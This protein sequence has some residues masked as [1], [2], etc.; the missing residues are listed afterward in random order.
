MTNNQLKDTHSVLSEVLRL[1]HLS[2]DAINF[3]FDQFKEGEL[4]NPIHALGKIRS[5][6]NKEALPHEFF[7]GFGINTLILD[8]LHGRLSLCENNF[9]DAII[10]DTAL[11]KWNDW[12]NGVIMEDLKMLFEYAQIVEFDKWS[13]VKHAS[14][15][16]DNLR[17]DVIKPI[18]RNDFDF[19][20]YLG[21]TKKKFAF[22][23]DEFLDIVCDFSLYGRVTLVLDEQNIDNLW[24]MFFKRNSYSE[25]SI[26]PGFREKCRSVFDLINIQ[27]L[28]VESFPATLM[29]SGQQQFEVETRNSFDISRIDKNHFDAGYILGLLL[30]MDISHSIV[31]GIA[32]S[33]VYTE[34]GTKPNRN[35]LFYYLENW[36]REKESLKPD[37][38]QLA[39]G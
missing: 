5:I 28:L 7:L 22:E 34:N 13:D 11:N 37:E 27:Y 9:I 29:Y 30:K 12:K 38:S 32:V 35:T 21:D 8:A 15:L 4:L 24:A 18:N 14:D 1:L 10:N 23:V 26:L 2:G 3:Y 36:M 19:I 6:G 16:W 33:G 17:R 25:I 39:A 20:F 31:L